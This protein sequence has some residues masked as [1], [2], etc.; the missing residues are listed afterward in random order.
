MMLTNCLFCINS[1]TFYV[2][3]FS[4]YLHKVK[5]KKKLLRY[6]FLETTLTSDTESNLRR[7]RKK[8]KKFN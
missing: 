6:L 4:S 2:K 8:K 7:G 5:K 3:D 1:G